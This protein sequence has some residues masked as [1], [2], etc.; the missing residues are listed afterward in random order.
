M[1]DKFADVVDMTYIDESENNLD[2]IYDFIN[3]ICN[4]KRLPPNDLYIQKT[5]PLKDI[6]IVRGPMIAYISMD[7]I[8]DKYFDD[9]SSDSGRVVGYMTVTS[10]YHDGSIDL[11][12][13]CTNNQLIPTNQ[14]M[15][16]LL[17]EGYDKV[18]YNDK[19]MIDMLF[20]FMQLWYAIQI[21]LLHPRAEII[22]NK[23]QIIP[24]TR[25]SD[26]SMRKSMNRR[27][28]RYIK[29]YLLCTDDLNNVLNGDA[30]KQINRH[31]LSWYVIGHYRQY[32]N[33]HRVFIQGYWKG[34][35]RELK[36]NLDSCERIVE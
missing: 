3:Q 36:R 34:E 19:M 6:V 15:R 11:D 33:G 8:D 9:L 14:R 35:L 32:K 12:I 24:T 2:I 20:Q 30:K 18:S 26:N 4:G 22:K 31:C 1:N 29:R 23:S 17:N 21:L 25:I 7:Y 13:L 27:K 10:K 5:I 28:V 16:V